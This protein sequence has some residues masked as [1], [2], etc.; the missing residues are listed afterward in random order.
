MT[1]VGSGTADAPPD[2]VVAV[3]VL[4]VEGATPAEAL[5]ACGAAQAAVLPVLGVPAAA[6]GVSVA[7]AWDHERNR[8]G[9]PVA[10]SR[11]SV[12]LPD[13]AQ[14]GEVVTRALEAGGKAA[15][16]ES[17]SPVVSDPSAALRE[18]RHVA[19]AEARA[20]AEQYAVLAGGRLGRCLSV[21][22]AVPQS[23]VP[24][25][26]AMK[27]DFA[28]ADGAQPVIASVTATWELAD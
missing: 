28:V 26:V 19:F 15:R 22:E 27:A 18:A 16:L 8:P 14:A 23:S 21:S 5:T 17:L 13:L 11:L 3:L 10:T 7:P 12:R 6:A 2:A 24:V 9:R 25:R 4:E 20:A 1:T